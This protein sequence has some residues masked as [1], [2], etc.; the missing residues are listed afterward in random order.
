MNTI[1][2]LVNLLSLSSWL[3]EKN[4]QKCMTWCLELYSL[5]SL[6]VNVDID[7]V[8]STNLIYDVD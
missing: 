3:I 8:I 6:I 2:V 4:L 1:K 7:T 5:L